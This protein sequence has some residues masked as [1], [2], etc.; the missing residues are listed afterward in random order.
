M[1]KKRTQI[2]KNKGNIANKCQKFDKADLVTQSKILKE[3]TFSTLLSLYFVCE[4]IARRIVDAEKKSDKLN[5]STLKVRM[6]GLGILV[7]EH[8]ID[9]I[10]KTALNTDKLR[11][12]RN[13]RN[14]VVHGCSIARRDYAI[15]YFI[16]Y[17]NAMQTFF[18]ECCK[19]I[20][21]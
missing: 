10:F 2:K 8:E 1:V 20:A 18:N 17:L 3:D 7:N 9:L 13:I 12:F 6:K 21:K 14:D 15:R 11:S 4:K 5:V 16:N 19:V